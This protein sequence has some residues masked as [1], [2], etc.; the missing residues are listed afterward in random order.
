LTFIFF[1]SV[2]ASR[3]LPCNISANTRAGLDASGSQTRVVGA[4]YEITQPIKWLPIV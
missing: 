3:I 2:V 4:P 1:S